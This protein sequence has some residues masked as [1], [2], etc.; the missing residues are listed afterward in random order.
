[1]LLLD[2]DEDD[3]VEEEVKGADVVVEEEREVEEQEE[4]ADVTAVL[5]DPPLLGA[6]AET[7]LLLVLPLLPVLFLLDL[8][9]AGIS[10]NFNFFLRFP[11]SFSLSFTSALTQAHTRIHTPR[12]KNWVWG[13]YLKPTTFQ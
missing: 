11:R 13:A 3:E 7:P 5:T 4:D 2:D 1:M 6:T 12:M 10:R 8:W 9:A